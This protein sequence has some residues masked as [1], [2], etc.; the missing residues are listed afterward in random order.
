MLAL[1]AAYWICPTVVY[2]GPMPQVGSVDT[3]K[4]AVQIFIEDGGKTYG[5]HLTWAPGGWTL[6]GV[7]D[8]RVAYRAPNGEV[9]KVGSD[10]INRREHGVLQIFASEPEMVAFLPNYSFYDF[11]L[12]LDRTGLSSGA[13]VV[14]MEFV[15]NDGSEADD[16][17]LAKVNDFLERYGVFDHSE[18]L[19]LDPPTRFLRVSLL[20][21]ENCS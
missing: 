8:H 18:N 15:A 5:P 1:L 19:S 21:F 6:A 16:N 3:A 2:K 4:V 14:A 11:S 20:G 13:T 10:K 12:A 7:G 9:Y 17:D